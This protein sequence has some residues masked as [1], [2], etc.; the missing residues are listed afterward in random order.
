MF[1]NV[2]NFDNLLQKILMEVLDLSIYQPLSHQI[3]Y[4]EIIYPTM[5]LN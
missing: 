1:I 5:S 2:I 4:F 3:D